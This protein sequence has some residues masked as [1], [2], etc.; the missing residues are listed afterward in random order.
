MFNILLFQNWIIIRI[1]IKAIS[2]VII[3]LLINITFSSNYIN[4]N[5]SKLNISK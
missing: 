1:L 4:K 3:E 5:N 2:N